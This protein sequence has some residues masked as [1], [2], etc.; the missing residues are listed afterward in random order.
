MPARDRKKSWQIIIWIS[1]LAPRPQA[2]THSRS[3]RLESGSVDDVCSVGEGLCCVCHEE[4][5]PRT[6]PTTPYLL[7]PYITSSTLPTLPYLALPYL[8]C[9]IT[10]PTLPT[11]PY[12]TVPYL[13]MPS[14]LGTRQQ[15]N[16]NHKED[17]RQA[18][19]NKSQPPSA[20]VEQPASN[21][22]GKK[23]KVSLVERR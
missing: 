8:T 7:F 13:A 23:S 16:H 18:S 22:K 19:K 2:L 5:T 6:Y 14:S 3:F 17:T 20:S 9:H 11:L 1:V 12:L 4:T 15:P 10:L 21:G